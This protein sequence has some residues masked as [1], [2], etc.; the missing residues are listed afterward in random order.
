ML[1]LIEERDHFVELILQL[2][3]KDSVIMFRPSRVLELGSCFPGTDAVLVHYPKRRALLG[4]WG[5]EFSQYRVVNTQ[6]EA[7]AITQLHRT[8]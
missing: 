6:L 8:E 4:R 3:M 5:C 7:I 1:I 2:G